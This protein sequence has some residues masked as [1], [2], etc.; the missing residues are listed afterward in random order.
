MSSIPFIFGKGR[1]ASV[2]VENHVAPWFKALVAVT[3]FALVLLPPLVLIDKAPVGAI[4]AL[5]GLGL[6]MSLVAGTPIWKGHA[7]LFNPTLL[8]TA[9]Y[10]I[11]FWLRPLLVLA[12]PA[13]YSLRW[14]PYS[15]GGML[16]ANWLSFAGYVVF[17]L[18]Y[19][20]PLGAILSNALPQPARNLRKDRAAVAV[21]LGSLLCL[22]STAYF[23]SKAN[24]SIWD[25]YTTATY[26]ERVGLL[27]GDGEMIVLLRFASWITAVLAYWLFLN[28]RSPLRRCLLAGVPVLMVF[29]LLSF[30][31][32]TPIVTL[33]GTL[34]VIRN[35]VIRP[36]SARNAI[37]FA[38]LALIAL[39]VWGQYRLNW[40]ANFIQ[41]YDPLTLTQKIGED[42]PE[43]DIVAAIT[44]YYP[45]A[46]DYYYGRLMWETLY[47][48]VPRRFWTGKPIWYGVYQVSNDVFPG[49]LAVS[50]SGGF[51]GTFLSTSTVGAGYADFG[52]FGAMAAMFIFGILWR[53]IY[54]YVE[55]KSATFAA[56]ALFGY[57]WSGLP[58][59]MR[60]FST[61]ILSLSIDVAGAL[62][63]F[64]LVGGGRNVHPA[65]TK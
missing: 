44:D 31:A 30:G 65:L 42:F 17:C 29:L 55:G 9:I 36:I 56:A 8:Y 24:R 3:G 13:N 22:L 34:L 7:S 62:L 64:A 1:Q 32:R 52:W 4:A 26:E 40:S 49:L 20:S 5:S 18:G 28:T 11:T 53:A 15:D 2:R 10:G 45:Q 61:T 46:Q 25:V 23:L 60:F 58:L 37:V 35:Y 57:C 14:I 51:Q 33:L 48:L 47:S 12:A 27:S 54:R 19:F 50:A 43:W 21:I 6:A 41:D 16:F 63:V 59:H 39:A 38:V